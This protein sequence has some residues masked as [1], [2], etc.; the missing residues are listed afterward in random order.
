MENGTVVL[1][2][3]KEN[4]ASILCQAMLDETLR[5]RTSLRKTE[6]DSIREFLTESAVILLGNTLDKQNQEK[7]SDERHERQPM[8]K[9]M[10]AML[11]NYAMGT[12]AMLGGFRALYMIIY[13]M[14]R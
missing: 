7:H 6:R 4:A 9:E 10:L 14:G 12:L 3:T 11:L 5:L 1:N 2:Y 13:Y 8:S